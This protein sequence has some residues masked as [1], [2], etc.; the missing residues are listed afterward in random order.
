VVHASF[1][2]RPKSTFAARSRGAQWRAHLPLCILGSE[3]RWTSREA[4][5]EANA[6]ECGLRGG[7]D[8]GVEGILG[9]GNGADRE[10]VIGDEA[11][12]GADGEGG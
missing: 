5:A 3:Y 6:L 1:L 11:P 7:D 2:D 12:C 10:V 4:K 8:A 9:V